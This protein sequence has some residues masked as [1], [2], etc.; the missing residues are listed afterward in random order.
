MIFEDSKAPAWMIKKNG[1]Y[2]V[3][4][5]NF[6]HKTLALT[7]ASK[8]GIYPKWIFSEDVFSKCDWKTPIETSILDLYKMRAQQLRD[9]YDH[10][11]LAYSG[12]ADSDSVLHSFIDNNIKLDELVIHWPESISKGWKVSRDKSAANIL[13]EWELTAKP[14]IEWLK[15]HH[16]DIKITFLDMTKMTDEHSEDMFTIAN[17]AIDYIP[18]KRQ[19]QM[20]AVS[21]KL[22]NQGVNVCIIY[23]IDKPTFNIIDDEFC[24][25]FI[26]RMTQVVSDIADG[27]ERNIEYFYW[28]EDLPELLIKQSQIFYNY[29][30]H[31]SQLLKLVV[32]RNSN[33]VVTYK[34]PEEDADILRDLTATLIYPRWDNTKF[35]ASKARNVIT[36]EHFDFFRYTN[37]GD[38]RFR[39]SHLSALTTQLNLIDD[40]YFVGGRRPINRACSY[41]AFTSGKYS[42]GPVV[43]YDQ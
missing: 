34:P 30:K 29:F 7:E 37:F 35:Q 28:A 21:S 24:I 26:D 1:Y 43:K 9:K 38:S 4:N 32:R 42:M 14:K 10:V 3:G 6:V 27:K 23:G 13:S 31:N 19:R 2:K 5:K 39:D 36:A 20:H 17:D 16:P 41:I 22:I 33:N 11:M 15:K 40:K 12:G 8:S 25:I 18:I